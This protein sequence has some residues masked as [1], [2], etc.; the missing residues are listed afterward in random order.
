[1]SFFGW[2]AYLGAASCL[3]PRPCLTHPP[4]PQQ[5]RARDGVVSDPS[6]AAGTTK[7]AG[8]ARRTNTNNCHCRRRHRH[9][10][11]RCPQQRSQ[12]YCTYEHQHQA[13]DPGGPPDRGPDPV[14]PGHRPAPPGI[15]SPPDRESAPMGRLPL[16]VQG[17]VHPVARRG[18]HG[19]PGRCGGRPRRA[20]GRWRYHG[21]EL[22]QQQRR[23][24][25]RR[26]FFGRG[27]GER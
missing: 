27:R 4:R 6:E 22:Q 11:C 15:G 17:A 24:R 16:Q 5:H 3:L 12:D 7:G 13:G 18:A 8:S 20:G 1:M 2:L 21:G 26:G 14:L 25:W 23:Q 9:N 10:T 19:Q